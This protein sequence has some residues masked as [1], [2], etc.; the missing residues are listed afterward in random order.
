M[1]NTNRLDTTQ[2]ATEDELWLLV[3]CTVEVVCAKGEI[4]LRLSPSSST[5]GFVAGTSIRI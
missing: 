5:F 2:S 3:P 4:T 1:T